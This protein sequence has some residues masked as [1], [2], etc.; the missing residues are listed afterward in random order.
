MRGMTCF[1]EQSL[2]RVCAQFSQYQNANRLH[3]GTP[4]TQ[5]PSIR[6]LFNVSD[7]PFS[8]RNHVVYVRSRNGSERGRERETALHIYMIDLEL[9]SFLFVRYLRK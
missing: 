3:A 5:T 9:D 2:F 7:F 6:I 4:H 8:R 1:N